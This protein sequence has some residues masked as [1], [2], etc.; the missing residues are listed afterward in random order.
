MNG[1]RKMALSSTLVATGFGINS[2]LCQVPQ[3][4]KKDYLKFYTE[5]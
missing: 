1:F 2:L 5:D 4:D 3:K